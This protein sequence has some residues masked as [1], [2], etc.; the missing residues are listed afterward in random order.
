[1]YIYIYIYIYIATLFIISWHKELLRFLREILT[2]VIYTY[3]TGK[4]IPQVMLSK[5]VKRR[6]DSHK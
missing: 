5:Y 1:V 3:D 6:H 2:Y 4:V